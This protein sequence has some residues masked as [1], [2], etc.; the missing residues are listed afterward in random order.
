MYNILEVALHFLYCLTST[1][2]KYSLLWGDK[3]HF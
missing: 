1:F 3:V 2:Q